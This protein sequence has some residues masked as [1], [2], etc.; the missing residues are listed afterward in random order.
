MLAHSSL[1]SL[2]PHCPSYFFSCNKRTV[3]RPKRSP[4]TLRYSPGLAADELF[5]DSEEGSALLT[6][7]N[8]EEGQRSTPKNAFGKIIPLSGC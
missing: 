1:I 8:D 2:F 5:K 6:F 4:L 3:Q 7:A